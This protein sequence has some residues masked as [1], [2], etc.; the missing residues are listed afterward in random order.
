MSVEQPLS[1]DAKAGFLAPYGSSS[2]RRAVADFV[3]DI[4]MEADHPSRP[5]LAAVEA[6]LAG[7]KGKPMLLCWGMR[8]FCFDQ[9]FLEG[10]SQRFPLAQRLL[11]AEGGHYVLEDAG[12]AALGPIGAFFAPA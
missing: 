4:P 7:L 11:F 8:D 5:V 12:E 6:S 1:P 9:S 3:A 10:F 2:V